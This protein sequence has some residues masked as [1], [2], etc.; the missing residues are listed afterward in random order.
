MAVDTF[1]TSYVIYAALAL[2]LA[3]PVSY[4][5]WRQGRM[6]TMR[7]FFVAA[8]VIALLCSV[9][10]VV[11]ERQVAQCLDASLTDC[12]DSGAVGLQLL[13]VGLYTVA[14]WFN[15]YFMWRD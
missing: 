11:S 7:N 6:A 8:L 3:S 5:T 2:V 13:F 12:F 10:S 4:V 15:A 1:I 9:L 14:A